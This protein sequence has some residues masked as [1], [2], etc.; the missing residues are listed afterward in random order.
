[1]NLPYSNG[2]QQNNQNYYEQSTSNQY[3]SNM[4]FLQ[5]S[6]NSEGFEKQNMN[7][8]SRSAALSRSQSQG[9]TFPGP[10]QSYKNPHQLFSRQLSSQPLNN[11]PQQSIYPPAIAVSQSSENP[12]TFNQPHKLQSSSNQDPANL[13]NNQQQSIS[14][15]QQ[16]M[17]NQKQLPTETLG[18]ANGSHFPAHSSSKFAFPNQNRSS[19]SIN[20]GGHHEDGSGHISKKRVVEVKSTSQDP[21]LPDT[22]FTEQI[23]KID[24]NVI[25]GNLDVIGTVIAKGYMRYSDILLKENIEDIVDALDI[26][27]NLHGRSYKWNSDAPVQSLQKG[28]RVIGLIAQEVQKFVPA[29]V[30]QDKDGYLYVDYVALVPIIVTAI[31]ERIHRNDTYRREIVEPGNQEMQ[32]HIDNTEKIK[33]SIENIIENFKFE[34]YKYEL[35]QQQRIDQLDDNLNE[36]MSN[37]SKYLEDLDT[38]NHIKNEQKVR[39]KKE[40]LIFFFAVAFFVAAF[41]VAWYGFNLNPS[42]I[43]ETDNL[44]SNPSFELTTPNNTAAGWMAFNEPYPSYSLF[45]YFGDNPM[46]SPGYRL[47]LSNDIVVMPI[48]PHESGS[49]ALRLGTTTPWNYTVGSRTYGIEQFFYVNNTGISSSSFKTLDISLYCQIPNNTMSSEKYFD[50]L[51]NITPYYTGPVD[52]ALP[53]SIIGE[54]K[55]LFNTT[56]IEGGRI[57]YNT[58]AGEWQYTN[59]QANLTV[60]PKTIYAFRITFEYDI[61]SPSVIYCD[62]FR[63]SI[64]YYFTK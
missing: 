33:E 43:R 37:C 8:P 56:A 22:N 20:T 31:H 25:T 18:S 17:P 61:T 1:M 44:L 39:I 59:L 9:N 55:L 7:P 50:L 62:D 64:S 11:N 2:T 51:V 48:E 6:G 42:E 19:H 36:L 38:V 15:N 27:K 28:N 14:L 23:P 49:V 41:L 32:Q 54:V 30:R 5:N 29:S 13:F 3:G 58:T 60:W 46:M 45:I 57:Q 16:L 35:L 63:V 10:P 40:Y 24:D 4:A 26:V 12:N 21:M 52:P 34:Q 53:E 47:Y